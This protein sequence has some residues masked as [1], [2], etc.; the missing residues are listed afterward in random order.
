MVRLWW[1]FRLPSGALSH[2]PSDS[3]EEA[4]KV[5]R[6]NSYEKA[7]IEEWPCLGT[8]EATREE[9]YNTP[10]MKKDE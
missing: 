5:L 4:R 9:V 2:V 6:R 10:M 7:P 3:E 1:V 8:K